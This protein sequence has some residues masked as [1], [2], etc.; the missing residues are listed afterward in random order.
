[1]GMMH[2]PTTNALRPVPNH[3]SVQLKELSELRRPEMPTYDIIE[4]DPL[5]DS[6]SMTPDGPCSVRKRV[7]LPADGSLSLHA[8]R[9]PAPRA[10]TP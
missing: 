5:L 2:D 3:H 9:A 7:A 4:Y 10:P 6:A 8:R 1:M